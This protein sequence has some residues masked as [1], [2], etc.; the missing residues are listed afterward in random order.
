[1]ILSIVLLSD[2][3]KEMSH[4]GHLGSEKREP[5]EREGGGGTPSIPP[6]CT[7]TGGGFWVT[8]LDLRHNSI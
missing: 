2:I 4:T 6:T 5:L 7:D 1:M 3:L 8:G